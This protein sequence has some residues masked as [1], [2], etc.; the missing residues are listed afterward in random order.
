MR[1]PYIGITD[2]ETIRQVEQMIDVF[3]KAQ[4]KY[5]SSI[6]RKLMI[7]VM[8]SYKTLNNISSR[9][10]AIWVKKE[11]I[12][13]LFINNPSVYNTLHYA[14]YKGNTNSEHLLRATEY[15]GE[16]IQSLQL[17]M[18]WPSVEMLAEFKK[19]R[20]EIDLILQVGKPAFKQ[21]NNDPA[22]L[23]RQ[24]KRYESIIE[25]VL[26]DKSMGQGKAMNAN[27]LLIYF[28]AIIDSGINISLAGAGGLSPKNVK[29]A[30][31]LFDYHKRMSVDAQTGLKTNYNLEE[32]T[33]WSMA[34][35]YIVELFKMLEEK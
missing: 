32:P 24:L 10:S 31:P 14:D 33:N 13:F 30:Q 25:F 18:I 21:I 28:K 26:L 1:Y 29:I 16:N 17:D 4:E 27:E 34:T 8:I 6:S 15:G 2:F 7:G 12:K 3:D 20:P 23:V 11:L 35:E 19:E 9:W 5:P 22:Q